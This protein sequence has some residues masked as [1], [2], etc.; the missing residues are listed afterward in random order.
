MA[1]YL[2]IQPRKS[3]ALLLPDKKSLNMKK[4][5][6]IF[7]VL[8]VNF[9][10]IHAQSERFSKDFE[11]I[12]SELTKWDPVRG[13]WLAS[14]IVAMSKKEAIP[15]RTFPEDFTPAEM[16][17]LVP[18]PTRNAVEQTATTNLQNATEADRNQWNTVASVVSRPSCK[19]TI[20]R[21]YGDPHLSSFDGASYSFQTVG[22]FVLAKSASQNFEIQTR[23]QPQSDDFS[24]NTAVAMNVAGD[25]VGIYPNQKPDNVSTSALRVNGAA[26]N[27]AGRTYFL[28]NGGTIR[29]SSNTYVITWPTGEVVNAQVRNSILLNFINLTVQVNPCAQRDLQ[30][31]LGNANGSKNDDFEIRTSGNRPAYLAFSSFGNDQM[32]AASNAAEKEYLAFL[33]RDYAREFRVISENSLFDYGFGQNTFSYTDESFPRV[34]RTVGDLTNDR[35]NSARRNCEEQG[36]S[37]EEMRGCIYDNAYL[38]IP[39]SP[40]PVINDP[41]TG[42]V[43][44]RVEKPIRNVNPPAAGVREESNKVEREVIVPGPQSI[45][46]QRQ[47]TNEKPSKITKPV[48]TTPVNDEKDTK[49]AVIFS[50]PEPTIEKPK[51][52]I[53]SKP[54][55]PSI[56]STP[57][58]P[59]NP[60]VKPPAP[61]PA[62]VITPAKIGKG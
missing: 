26:I 41:T 28:P 33:A 22:E 23:Q 52:S 3:W 6:Y 51:P 8:L 10:T 37:A 60:T 13:E 61:A 25:R 36:V 9:T 17:R 40:R 53:P 29:Y 35:Q 15:D 49:P 54:S 16:L 11:P 24:L 21:S 45:E 38:E 62:K 55:T 12:R 31:L 20:G 44:G 32:Q 19:P 7:S 1:Y 14:S 5:I 42:A 2:L 27:L 47:T 18:Q 39:P 50:K 4:N 56:P 57:S 59:A 43:L 46:Q 30:G 58:K 34:H 48:T